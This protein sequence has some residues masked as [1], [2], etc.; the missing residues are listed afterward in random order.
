MAVPYGLAPIAGNDLA[1]SRPSKRPLKAD[2]ISLTTFEVGMLACMGV[3][4]RISRN[5]TATKR[6]AGSDDD[7]DAGPI[8]NQLSRKLVALAERGSKKKRN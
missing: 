6:R 1:S 7:S 2:S 5:F 4:R 8:R 3:T